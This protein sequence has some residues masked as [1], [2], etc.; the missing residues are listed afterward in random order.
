MADLKTAVE[1]I[2]AEFGDA[3]E[4]VIEFR[5]EV[6][7]VVTPEKLTEV[8][9]FC[10]D[11]TG[12]KFNFLSDVC[13]VDYYPEEPRFAVNYHLYS[14]LNTMS[15]RLKVFAS[16][17]DPVVPTVTDVFPGANFQEREVYDMFGITIEGHPDPRRILMPHDWTGHP[18]RKDYPLGYEEVQFTFN[19]DRIQAKKPQPRE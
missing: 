18:L 15:L 13:G 19:Y 9:T 16:E 3:I 10:R 14:M 2:Q 1:T 11:T 6:T 7:L 17:E 4:E 5:D 12:L 8:M